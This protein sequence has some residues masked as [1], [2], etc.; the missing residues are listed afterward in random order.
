VNLFLSN[1]VDNVRYQSALM[2]EMGVKEHE[3]TNRNHLGAAGLTAQPD[4]SPE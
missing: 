4:S 2:N 3:R 1:G